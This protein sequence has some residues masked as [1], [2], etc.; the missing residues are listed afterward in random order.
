MNS[1]S[2]VKRGVGEITNLFWG[3]EGRP[4]QGGGEGKEGNG[5]AAHCGGG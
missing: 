2:M 1:R 3:A 5:A 4:E